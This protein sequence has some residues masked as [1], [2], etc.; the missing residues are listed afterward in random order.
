MVAKATQIEQPGRRATVLAVAGL[1]LALFLVA[2][3]QTVVG[4]ALPKIIADLNGFEHYAWVTTAYLLASTAMIPVIGKLGDIYGRK[5]FIVAGVA[6]FLVGSALCGAAW[7]MTELILFRGLQGLGAGMIFSNIFT[8]VADIF[9]DPARRA[10]YQGVFFSVFALTSVIGP[11]MG[12]W[13]TDNLSWRWGFYINL[14]L[15]IF[16]LFALPIVLHQSARRFGVKIDYLG[17][18]TVT[19]SVVSLLLALSWVGEG[20]DWDATRV[21]IGFVVAGI[22]LAAF[23]PVELRADEPIIPLSLFESRVFGS[24]ALLMFMVGIGMFGIILYTPL[25]VQGVLGMSATG[26]GTV[27]T[28]LVLSMTAMGIICGQI[29]ARV[30]RIKPFMIA[31]SIVMTFGVYLLTTLDVDSMQ[32][33]VALFLMVTGL[34]LG[35]L[36]PSATLAVQSTVEKR[37]LGVAT[38]ATQFIRSLGSTVGTAIIGSLVT[39]G[40]ADYLKD[41]APPQAPG[42]LIN[43]LEDPNAL[44]SEKARDA[45]DRVASAFPGGEQVVNQILDAAR[46]GLSNSIHDGFVFIL[47]AVAFAIVAAVVMKNV[48]LGDQGN[49]AA[50]VAAPGPSRQDGLVAAITLEY[51]ARRIEGA[52]GDSPNLISAALKLVPDTEGSERDRAQL[53]V[54]RVLRPLA[55]EALG[56]S[57]ERNGVNGHSGNSE[58][59]DSK[60]GG[61][62]TP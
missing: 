53:A 58:A 19:A 21:V 45:L 42:R 54:D 35:P 34:G 29:I 5:W 22:L 10:K 37:L 12:G 39:S 8:S 51:L 27:L 11:A 26:S 40:Y 61:T 57:L 2:L 6:I 16:S 43:A 55:L 36:M 44:V 30:K 33:N 28:P 48:R 25:F 41:N 3:D 23:I 56:S 47:V 7:G 52:N 46:T 14:P 17:A 24:A 59:T 62:S 9:P 20:Y 50:P 38:S 49:E 32:R 18:A 1:M 13:I 60:G 4:T 15:G 31:G